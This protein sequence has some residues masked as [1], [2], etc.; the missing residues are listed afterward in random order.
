MLVHYFHQRNSKSPKFSGDVSQ[1]T[2]TE[3]TKT[4]AGLF[5]S[6]RLKLKSQSDYTN[7]DCDISL[8]F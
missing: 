8:I 3:Q 2:Q 4:N 7:V 6:L 1:M 5:D